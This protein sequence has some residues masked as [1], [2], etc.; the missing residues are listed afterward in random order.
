V[1]ILDA[2][3][4]GIDLF[5]TTYPVMEADHGHALLFSFP[6]SSSAD[7][8]SLNKINLWERE[9]RDDHR[10]LLPE[11]QCFACSNHTR[12]YIH[13]LLLVHEI[14]AH[15]LLNY[16]NIHHYSLFV[17]RIRKSLQAGTFAADKVAFLAA[18]S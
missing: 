1:E 8:S 12:S 14:L 9:F 3:E 13:H 18:G 2:V 6:A 10:P 17:S 16:H 4:D 15:T 7:G 11:C 5:D